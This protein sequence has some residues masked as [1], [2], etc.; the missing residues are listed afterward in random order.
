MKIFL[1][2]YFKIKV[3]VVV[4]EAS[5]VSQLPQSSFVYFFPLS[6]IYNI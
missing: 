6:I 4:D 5:S 3:I 1:T 2:E